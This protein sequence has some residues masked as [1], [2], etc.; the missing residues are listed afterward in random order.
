MP[1]L[2]DD[3]ITDCAREVGTA[4]F[5]HRQSNGGNGIEAVL[6]LLAAAAM[7]TAAGARDDATP[8]DQESI[9]NEAAEALKD[10]MMQAFRER[11]GAVN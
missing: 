8:G 11:F 4:L 1:T 2:S 9:S 6:I 3:Q 7:L 5:L 10:L